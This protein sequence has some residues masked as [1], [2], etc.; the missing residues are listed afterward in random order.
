L[1]FCESS[2]FAG[3]D[4]WRAPDIRELESLH[5]YGNGT[6]AIDVAL[7]RNV[8]QYKLWSSTSSSETPSVEPPPA[9]AWIFSGVILDLDKAE[10]RGM[11]VRAVRNA[12]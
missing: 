11:R 6:I 2:T 7:G 4:D 8:D 3:Y 5:Y 10:T 1:T 12:R 9:L